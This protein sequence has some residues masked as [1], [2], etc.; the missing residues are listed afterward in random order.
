[1]VV[2]AKQ[3]GWAAFQCRCEDWSWGKLIDEKGEIEGREGRREKGML[4]SFISFYWLSRFFTNLSCY[5]QPLTRSHSR[6]D[7][8][9]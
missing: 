2:Y 5:D 3:C 4:L 6:D 8:F 9:L 7:A 1:M